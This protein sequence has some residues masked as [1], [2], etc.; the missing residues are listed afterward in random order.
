MS[1]LPFVSNFILLHL[2]GMCACAGSNESAIQL[3]SGFGAVKAEVLSFAA[4]DVI[5]ISDGDS[6]DEPEVGDTTFTSSEQT[7]KRSRTDGGDDGKRETSTNSDSEDETDG[8]RRMF[9]HSYTR[10]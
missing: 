5:M 3:G 8:K 9:V 4:G 1:K 6:D 7:N 10:R 2:T